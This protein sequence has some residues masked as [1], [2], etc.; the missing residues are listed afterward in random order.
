VLIGRLLHAVGAN[1]HGHALHSEA[2]DA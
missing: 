1:A 2:I